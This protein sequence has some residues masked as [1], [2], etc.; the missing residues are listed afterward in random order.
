MFTEE[1]ESG[2]EFHSEKYEEEIHRK[3]N[4]YTQELAYK[5]RSWKKQVEEWCHF[6]ITGLEELIVCKMPKGYNGYVYSFFFCIWE[7]KVY[8]RRSIE[9]LNIEKF[10]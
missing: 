9:Q 10:C 5:Y 2:G 8:K 1:Q 6:A 4:V 7:T 3:C